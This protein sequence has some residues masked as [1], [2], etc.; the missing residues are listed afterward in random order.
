VAK[1]AIAMI[2]VVA[3][4]I[5]CNISL[6]GN[7]HDYCNSIQKPLQSAIAMLLLATILTKVTLLLL[8]GIATN[9]A[10]FATIF[11]C[12]NRPIF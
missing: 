7:N 5:D 8:E 12:G 4:I 6:H 3:T 9:M 11:H 10:I 2:W 1:K